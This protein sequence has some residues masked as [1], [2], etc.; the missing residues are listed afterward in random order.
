[1]N[2]LGMTSYERRPNVYVLDLYG[3]ASAEALRAG[4]KSAAWMDYAVRVHDVSLAIVYPDLFHIPA[5]WTPLARMC[6][7][8]N[9]V[10]AEKC[11]VFFSTTPD[12]TAQIRKELIQFGKTIPKE[13]TFELDPTR[14]LV[15]DL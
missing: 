5:T 11:V 8:E 6:G 9:V 15:G 3:L 14:D 13:D 1:M 10:S 4:D 2:D 7:P 12:A